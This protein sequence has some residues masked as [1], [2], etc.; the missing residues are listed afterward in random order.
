MVIRILP[1]LHDKMGHSNSTHTK[2]KTRQTIVCCF[3][4]SAMTKADKQEW[5]S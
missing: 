1:A 4:F 3:T 2:Y 5:T